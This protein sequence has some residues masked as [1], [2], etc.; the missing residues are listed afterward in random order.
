LARAFNRARV[1]RPFYLTAWVFLLHH[2]H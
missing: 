2:W 1:L